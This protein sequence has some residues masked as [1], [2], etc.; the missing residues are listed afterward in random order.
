MATNPIFTIGVNS[1]DV[2]S[3]T[4]EAKATSTKGYKPRG[5]GSPTDSFLILL[6][7]GSGFITLEDGSGFIE[8]EAGP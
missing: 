8:L 4:P 1:G 6:E 3:H 7:D 5:A 2:N